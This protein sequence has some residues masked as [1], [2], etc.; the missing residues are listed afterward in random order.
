MRSRF[1][2]VLP[3]SVNP[4][5]PGFLLLS[6]LSASSAACSDETASEHSA[7]STA[8]TATAGTTKVDPSLERTRKLSRGE[9]PFHVTEVDW[10]T[11]DK[12]PR[13]SPSLLPQS[14]QS[15]LTVCPVPALLPKEPSLLQVVKATRGQDW[16]GASMTLE[17]INVF[18]TGTR[19]ERSLPSL[20][21][22]LPEDE[23]RVV[24]F[25]G[26]AT[27]SFRAWGA[28]YSIEVECQR[29]LEDSRCTE[30]QYIL[31]LAHNLGVVR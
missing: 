4:I 29:P 2:W 18:V 25:T 13:I 11:A 17:D 5:T 16:Y 19:K 26:I 15:L 28:A 3:G 23:M 22:R 20:N 30:D 1:R 7:H 24:R 31:S 12:A 21:S 9:E 10:N 8:L 6:A 14:S 27:V